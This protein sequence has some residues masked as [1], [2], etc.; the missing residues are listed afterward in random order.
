MQESIKRIG[1]ISTSLRTFSRSDITH[2]EPFNLHEGIDSTLMIL[3][4]RLKGN[5]QHPPI[6]V[7]QHYG[8]IPEV[9]CY[10]GQINQV[11]MN[12]IANAIDALEESNQ[13]RSYEAIEA[14]P[15]QITIH[16]KMNAENS[17][18]PT[19]VVIRIADNGPGIPESVKQRIFDHLFTT[20]S[21]GKGTGL[22]LSIARQIVEQRHHGTLACISIPGQGT[23]FIIELPIELEA[24]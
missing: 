14:N 23:E 5:D 6:E 20:K 12:I 10:P 2:K 18:E 21:V 8:D 16:T 17:A 22:G 4:H 19:S 24:A 13:G 15:N 11:F 7:V 3:K 1:G 9:E